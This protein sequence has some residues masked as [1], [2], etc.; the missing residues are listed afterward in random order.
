[1]SCEEI[2]D[3]N[4]VIARDDPQAQ[5]FILNSSFFILDSSEEAR[6]QRLHNQMPPVGHDEQQDLEWQGD[7]GGR[8]HHHAH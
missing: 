8:E 3:R 4:I 7:R 5:F 6:N 2:L 1:V